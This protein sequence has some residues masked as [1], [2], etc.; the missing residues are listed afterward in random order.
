M[1]PKLF[2]NVQNIGSTLKEVFVAKITNFG[3]KNYYISV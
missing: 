2:W 3:R 1:A